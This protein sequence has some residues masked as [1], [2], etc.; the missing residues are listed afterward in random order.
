MW[1]MIE[2]TDKSRKGASQ[3]K[4]V[5]TL[6]G[7]QHGFDSIHN[8]TN[9]SEKL[10]S[11]ARKKVEEMLSS[12]KSSDTITKVTENTYIV[13]RKSNKGQLRKTTFSFIC[14]PSDFDPRKMGI[15]YI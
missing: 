1:K 12:V 6:V 10:G 4:A 9:R 13:A 2:T 8:C 11:S 15:R 5:Y 7:S 3:V 14:Y